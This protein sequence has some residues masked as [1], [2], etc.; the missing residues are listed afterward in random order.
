MLIWTGWGWLVPVIVFVVSLLTQVTS[1]EVTG[2]DQIYQEQPWLFAMSTLVSGGIVWF[3]AKYFDKKK[4]RVVI[5]KETG[6]EIM[7]RSSDA[8][9]FVPLR[10]WAFILPVIGIVYAFVD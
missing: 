8:L 9:F 3:L 5:D 1:Q 2:Q 4:G 10:F 6:Q 7:L